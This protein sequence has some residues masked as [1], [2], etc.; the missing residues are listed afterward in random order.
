MRAH[1]VLA[2][3]VVFTLVM[4]AAA[5]GADLDVVTI[6]RI[7]E[8]PGG[9]EADAQTLGVA[10]AGDRWVALDSEA[11]NLVPGDT[12]GLSDIFV[13][14]LA[15]GAIERVSVTST[16]EETDGRSFNPTID[17]AGRYVTFGSQ[18]ANLTGC[19]EC[20]DVFLHDRQT[21]DTINLSAPPGA[22]AD[23]ISSR[24]R[25]SADGDWVVFT[26]EIALVS[27]DTNGVTDVYLYEV[28]TAD[29]TRVSTTATGGQADAPSLWADV[30]AEGDWV[31]FTSLANLVPHAVDPTCVDISGEGCRNIY[32]RH[33]TT[34]AL[35]LV[36]RDISGGGP[37]GSSYTL[38]F[39]AR[40]TAGG[41]TV[42]FA[43]EATDLVPSQAAALATTEVNTQVFVAENRTA[44]S[45]PDAIDIERFTPTDADPN[46]PGSVS[47]ALSPDGRFVVF[48]AEPTDGG[49]SMFLADRAT[50]R[51]RR[52][53]AEAALTTR[54]SDFL[55]DARDIAFIATTPLVPDD[56]NL[57]NDAFLTRWT[58]FL[59]IMGDF[60]EAE[61]RWLAAEGITFGCTNTKYC[62][63]AGLTRGQAASLLARFLGLAASGSDAFGDDDGSV[64]EGAI[65][66]LADAGITLGCAPGLFCPD[67]ILTR[68]QM[69][70]LLA[71][72]L[73]LSGTVPDAFGDDDGSV[74]EPAINRLA[75]AGVTR[76]C[77]AGQFC[78]Y[79]PVRR[80]QMAGFLFRAAGL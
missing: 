71:R 17:A 42:T 24:A 40:E 72:A 14:D 13:L 68:A 65:D 4:A 67:D 57:L 21:G 15:T 22:P 47:P 76:G 59:D 46:F 63:A 55:A 54:S 45:D 29:L 35:T 11:G 75:D 52:L 23:R 49:G 6:E 9:I 26:S 10:T 60:F 25:I 36:T 70:S 73:G 64:H 12:N 2:G 50:G 79:K 18:A 34:G 19:T 80:D 7:S 69:A 44:L 37:N 27:N 31:A 32:I 5:V 77:T 56:T 48:E 38:D 1:R 62:P 43:S 53:V 61:I 74:H 20:G 8:G 3:A 16:G 28:A 33:R 30:S 66:A 78:P 39:P 41:W 58:P 51:I